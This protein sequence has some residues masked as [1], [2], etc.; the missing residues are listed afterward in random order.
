MWMKSPNVTFNNYGGLQERNG[1]TLIFLIS[2]NGP[3]TAM[4]F[5]TGGTLVTIGIAHP[6]LWNLYT[7]SFD[8]SKTSIYLNGSLMTP[9]YASSLPQS[10]GSVPISI[11]SDFQFN[12]YVAASIDDVRIYNRALSATEIQA[13]YNAEK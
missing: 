2:P 1:G 4:G 3:G 12:R 11:G 8:G 13:I 10:I 5:W 6:E 7:M 9:P